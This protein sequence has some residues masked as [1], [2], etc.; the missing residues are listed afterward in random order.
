MD[1]DNVT[2]PTLW[3]WPIAGLGAACRLALLHAVGADGFED[4]HVEDFGVFAA[5]S[6]EP[7]CAFLNL[8]FI[9]F[10]GS[11]APVSQSNAVL[12]SIGRRFN[13]GGANVEEQDRVDEL[14]STFQDFQGEYVSMSY[15]CAGAEFDKYKESFLAKSVPYYI[16]GLENVM[17]THGGKYLAGDSVT[18]AD[19]KAWGYVDCIRVLTGAATRPD[20]VKPWPRLHSWAITMDQLPAVKV[21]DEKYGTWAAN[22][23][24]AHWGNKR[25]TE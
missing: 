10:P 20:V 14:L 16:G 3:Y 25:T 15:S 1:T 2:K 21:Y 22:A 17:A 9:A 23:G 13:L 19:F 24:M 4:K 11:K 6:K 5:K 8:P 7:N 12:T 18:V